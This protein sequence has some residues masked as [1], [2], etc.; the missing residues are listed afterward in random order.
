MMNQEQKSRTKTKGHVSDS[1]VWKK[2]SIWTS[3]T[4]ASLWSFIDLS[5]YD[6]EREKRNPECRVFPSIYKY[7]YYQRRRAGFGSCEV[8]VGRLHW[9]TQISTRVLLW[10]EEV[11]M[12]QK[13]LILCMRVLVLTIEQTFLLQLPGFLSCFHVPRFWTSVERRGIFHQVQIFQILIQLPG[14]LIV[15]ITFSPFPL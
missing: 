11:C 8:T 9:H 5:A 12:Y 6:K 3:I 13:S 15:F 1:E 2:P 14:F 4:S 10:A 7:I